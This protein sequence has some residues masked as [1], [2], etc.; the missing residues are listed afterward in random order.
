MEIPP[1]FSQS[2]WRPWREGVRDSKGEE[3]GLKLKLRKW[4]RR[5]E[6][7]IFG[8][9]LRLTTGMCDPIPE[10]LKDGFNPVISGWRC[11]ELHEEPAEEDWKG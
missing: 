8:C 4:L 9:G 1:S 10:A 2:I 3:N 5:L 6:E 7:A 11:G